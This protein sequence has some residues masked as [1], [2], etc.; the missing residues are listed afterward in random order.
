MTYAAI[1]QSLD[2]MFWEVPAMSPNAQPVFADV[3]D[4][5]IADLETVLT[6]RRGQP[7]LDRAEERVRFYVSR[8]KE[9]EEIGRAK[10]QI[11]FLRA[12]EAWQGVADGISMDMEE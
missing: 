1:R 2:Q 6:P 8:A 5:D 9:A 11:E 12:A 7:D 10:L 3:T 4:A